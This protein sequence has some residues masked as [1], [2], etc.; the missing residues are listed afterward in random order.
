MVAQDPK[1]QDSTKPTAEKSTVKAPAQRVDVKDITHLTDEEKVKVAILQANGSALDGATINVA[2]DGTATIT[3]PDGSVVTIL[4]KDTV[5]QSA[6]GESVTQE[7]TPEYKL[8]NTPGGDKGG[9]TGSS[10]A[11][12][13]AG[14]GSQAG[15]SAHTGSQNSAQSQASKQLATEKESA[16]NAIEKAAKDKQDEIK[17]APLSDKE[18]AELLARVEAEKQAA[19][20]EIENAKTMEDV[21]EAETI[22]VQAIVMV[23]VPKRPVAPKTTSAPQATAGTM[24]DV[25]YQSPAGKQLPNTGSASSAALASLGLVVATSGFALLGRKTRRRK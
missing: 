8:E 2:G 24:Q 22:G 11:N 23:T 18:K 6:K 12:A 4:G 20:K 25:T 21:K 16:K 15:G 13:N 9:N 3:F 5:Q 1:A 7:A 10:D 14:G 19:L 17:G